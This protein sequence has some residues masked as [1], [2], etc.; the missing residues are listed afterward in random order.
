[1]DHEDVDALPVTGVPG[2]TTC[3]LITRSAI[4]RLLYA[5]HARQ[6]AKGEPAVAATESTLVG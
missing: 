1:M 3:G 5:H 2:S 6:H 4:R